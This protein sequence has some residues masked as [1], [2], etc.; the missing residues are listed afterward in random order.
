MKYP[1]PT[2]HLLPLHERPTHRV[3]EAGAGAC[4]LVELLAAVV[5]GP[6]Q[7][8]IA[9]ALLGRFGD[10]VG[11][12]RASVHELKRV[13]GL[14]PARAARLKAAL[15]LGQRLSPPGEDRPQVRSPADA[16]Q[17]L[18]PKM[19]LLEQEELWVINVDARNRVLAVEAV[20]RGLLHET[21]VR[22]CEVFRSAVRT[23]TAAAIIV[24]HNHPSGDCSPSPEDVAVTRTLAQTGELLGLELLDHIILGNGR[25]VSLRERGLGFSEV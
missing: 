22:P 1:S 25:F 11:L 7:I 20:Y 2:L 8:E 9:Y 17:L 18:M 10:M 6:Q 19:R 13:P 14:G 15:E 5:G 3:A 23:G 21:H 24:A 4:N 12:G 16:V